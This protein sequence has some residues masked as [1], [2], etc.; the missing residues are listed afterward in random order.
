MRARSPWRSRY[1]HS[2]VS[3]SGYISKMGV[4]GTMSDTGPYMM[5]RSRKSYVAGAWMYVMSRVCMRRESIA[6]LRFPVPAT[7]KP[8]NG[9]LLQ[10]DVQHAL[11]VEDAQLAVDA[12]YVVARG[13]FGYAELLA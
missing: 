8:A 11:A 9:L 7:R 5:E 10:D 4:D 2:V 12:A 6:R 1:S 13:A 3:P